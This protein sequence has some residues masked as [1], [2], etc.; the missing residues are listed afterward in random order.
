MLPK[1]APGTS[2]AQT[3]SRSADAATMRS[4]TFRQIDVSDAEHE[5]QV[6]KDQ[7][8]AALSTPVR[9]MCVLQIASS[10]IE[11]AWLAKKFAVAIS[12]VFPPVEPRSVGTERMKTWWIINFNQAKRHY[13]PICFYGVISSSLQAPINPNNVHLVPIWW[14]FIIEQL[15]LLGK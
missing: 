1:S 5:G 11:S 7:V 15:F 6:V 9:T 4:V 2:W 8:T 3:R 12:A 13:R 10:L 14:S